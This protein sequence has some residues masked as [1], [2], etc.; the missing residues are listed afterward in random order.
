MGTPFEY[1]RPT[2]PHEAVAMKARHG[3]RARFW[4]GGTDLMLGWQ[5]GTAAFDY[6]IDLGFLSGLDGIECGD[7]RIRIG[8]LVTLDELDRASGRG[9]LLEALG[10]T[11]RLMCT[12]QTRTIA[13]VGGNLCHA[14]PSADLSPLLLA[15]DAEAVIA[16]PTGERSI[17]LEDFI[18]GPNETALADDEILVEVRVPLPTRRREACYRR[19]ARTSVDIALTGVA[20]ALT[21]DGEGRIADARIALCAVAPV[22]LRS[23][24][25]EE[26][27]VGAELSTF[28]GALSAAAGERAAADARPITDLRASAEYRREMV[29]VLTRRAICEVVGKLAGGA[30]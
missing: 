14:A 18:R 29:R 5:Q 25:A 6:C 15:L 17:S 11:A 10:A 20:V 3:V 9:P 27:L 26:V 7:G 30:A 13:T 1:L 21:S 23:R 2:T 22:P 4:A 19:V 8:A 16:G 24:A 28:D 12:P